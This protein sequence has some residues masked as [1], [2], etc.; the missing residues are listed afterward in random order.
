MVNTPP[1]TGNAQLDKFLR[2]VAD[3]LRTLAKPREGWR[4]SDFS[5]DV[6]EVI[7]DRRDLIDIVSAW[8]RIEDLETSLS[9]ELK[10]HSDLYDSSLSL[11]EDLGG[12][13]GTF[14]EIQRWWD[15]NPALYLED[16]AKISNAL[17]KA[18][19]ALSNSQD[20]VSTASSAV[21]TASNSAARVTALEAMSG[22][23]P[24][25]PVDGQT[26]NLI[27]QPGTLTGEALEKLLNRA[28]ISADSPKYGRKDGDYDT[29]RPA[30]Q[31]A[32]DEAG[33]LNVATGSHVT[34]DLGGH[35]WVLNSKTHDGTGDRSTAKWYDAILEKP[36]GVNIVG[37]GATLR[38]AD[39]FGPYG[40]VIKNVTGDRE[41]DWCY[42]GGFEID[43]NARG[44]NVISRAA[45]DYDG[46]VTVFP[47]FG[48]Q[49]SGLPGDDVTIIHDVFYRDADTLNC[50]QI[51]AK[52][53]VIPRHGGV[54]LGKNAIEWH[55]HSTIYTT[56]NTVGGTQTWGPGYYSGGGL[57]SHAAVEIHGGRVTMQP[58]TVERMGF[59]A[60]ICGSNISTEIESTITMQKVVARETFGGVWL[61][62]TTGTNSD[63]TPANSGAAGGL[64]SVDMDLDLRLARDWHPQPSSVGD[65]WGGAAVS[66][67][68]GGGSMSPYPI[69]GGVKVRGR[70]VYD[71]VSFYPPNNE[72]RSSGVTAILAPGMV[73]HNLDVDLD[74][75]RPWGPGINLNGEF[76][77]GRVRVRVTDP[78]SSPAALTEGTSSA[79]KGAFRS[80]G[81]ISGKFTDMDISGTLI[82]T[83]VPRRAMFGLQPAT[84]LEMD[85]CTVDG[86]VKLA[87]TTGSMPFFLPFPVMSLSSTRVTQ[88]SLG[89]QAIAV[90]LAVGSTQTDIASGRVW[91]QKAAP[92]GVTWRGDIVTATT[93]ELE[94]VGSKINTV[95]KNPG[96]MVWNTDTQ[97]PV[98]AWSPV[99]STSW[100]DF[101]G[102]IVH[103][104][105]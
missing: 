26:A 62:S 40:N 96:S 41:K 43:F 102:E 87:D 54:D 23:S 42:V 11:S 59:V 29:H 21:S 94:S 30:I 44:G 67:T 75:V 101:S 52:H 32:L 68:T 77:G 53:I 38:V 93:A 18:E 14:S 55:D 34:V 66:F 69:T 98:F 3:D 33:E 7:S 35:E 22:L 89:L 104:P 76:S 49:L 103:T 85:R 58:F 36:S 27:S 50:A 37:R 100:R 20:A 60:N 71:E 45:G 86:E 51:A 63:G 15:E 17:S 84:P 9:E 28:V 91:T 90:P 4:L 39:N 95:D 1:L 56:V 19:A 64:T 99:P 73:V 47:R 78:A 31:A 79:L 25:S 46:P 70:V 88:R 92:S 16:R 74:V 72:N 82:D 12:L 48:V 97:K 105:T 24:E 5:A 81:V 61:W 2:S 65:R 8:G 10:K 57:A 6:S 13:A 83:R 80:L